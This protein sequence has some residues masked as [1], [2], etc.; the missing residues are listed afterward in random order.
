MYRT[1]VQYVP[2]R[3][4]MLPGTPRDFVKSVLAFSSRRP[5]KRE[6]K[7]IHLP[8]NDIDSIVNTNAVNPAFAPMKIAEQWGVDD[9]LWDRPWSKLSGGESQRVALAI[10][11]G[12]SGAQVLLLDGL[13]FIRAYN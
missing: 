2:Q 7:N 3:P 5:A 4:S 6:S 11:I 12:I 13:S 9:D 8:E 10:A 1:L